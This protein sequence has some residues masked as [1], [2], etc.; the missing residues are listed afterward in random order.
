MIL[1]MIKNLSNSHIL[2]QYQTRRVKHSYLSWYI[3]RNYVFV[4]F[5]SGHQSAFSCH[6]HD[7]GWEEICSHTQIQHIHTR[8]GKKIM[9]LC[10][11]VHIVINIILFYKTCNIKQTQNHNYSIFWIFFNK[12]DDQ[13]RN[14]TI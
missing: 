11:V 7:Y 1:S 13:I 9:S 4:G 14:F 3:Q 8:E 10:Q 6:L 5:E 2:K 12:H